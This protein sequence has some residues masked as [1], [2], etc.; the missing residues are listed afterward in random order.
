MNLTGERKDEPMTATEE[1]RLI[2]YL[3]NKG[4]TAEQILDLLEYIKR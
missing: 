3:E 4:W 1:I 2:Q